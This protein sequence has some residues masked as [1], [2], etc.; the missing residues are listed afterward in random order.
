M[1]PILLRFLVE[2]D[3]CSM[4]YQLPVINQRCMVQMLDNSYHDWSLPRAGLTIVANAAI[5]TGPALLG[6]RGPLCK[7]VFYYMQAW[8]LEFWCPRQNLRKKDLYL[9]HATQKLYSLKAK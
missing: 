3:Q 6:P 5:P 4:V 1:E 8:V 2:S 7:F 9:T